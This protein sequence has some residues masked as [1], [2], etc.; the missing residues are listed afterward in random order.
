[1]STRCCR[2]SRE[3]R[4]CKPDP[5]GLCV[6]RCDNTWCSCQLL[7]IPGYSWSFFCAHVYTRVTRA[8]RRRSPVVGLFINAGSFQQPIISQVYSPTAVCPRYSEAKTRWGVSLQHPTKPT[9]YLESVPGGLHTACTPSHVNSNKI[10]RPRRPMPPRTKR[11]HPHD[12]AGPLYYLLPC[13]LLAQYSCVASP[14]SSITFSIPDR[15]R[16]AAKCEAQYSCMA[17]PAALLLRTCSTSAGSPGPFFHTLL[18]DG[19]GRRRSPSSPTDIDTVDGGTRPDEAREDAASPPPSPP[20]WLPSPSPPR[21]PPLPLPPLLSL[22]S[23]AVDALLRRVEV[24]VLVLALVV[25]ALLDLDMKDRALPVPLPRM[26]SAR[27]N[28]PLRTGR[29]PR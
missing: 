19:R 3:K 22:D 7:L 8:T 16:G 4:G 6:A 9:Q 1:M 25:V 15:C 12:I 26:L 23:A 5:C 14:A 13:R 29:A 11:T 20:P 10:S 27:R 21:P 17:S 28:L 24:V 18:A 2:L